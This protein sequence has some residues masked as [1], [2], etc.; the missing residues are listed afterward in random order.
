MD[1]DYSR[2]VL[3]NRHQITRQDGIWF[4]HGNNNLIHIVLT[5]TNL[6][7]NVI[8]GHGI[9]RLDKRC[10]AYCSVGSSDSTQG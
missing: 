7:E 5:L 3:R 1:A 9:Q 10:G 4:R 8:P 6:S 2:F